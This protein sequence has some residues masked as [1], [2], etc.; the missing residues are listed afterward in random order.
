MT[1][2]NSQPPKT[3]LGRVMTQAINTMMHFGGNA[4]KPG[5]KVPELHIEGQTQP[6]S[7][8]GDRHTGGRSSSRD[9]TIRNET[10]SANHFLLRKDSEHPRHFVIQDDKSSNGIYVNNRKV[11]SFSLRNGDTIHLAPPELAQAVKITYRFTPPIWV[12]LIRYGLMGSGGF[13]GF[14]CLIFAWQWTKYPLNPLPSGVTG[15]VVIFSRD[16]ATA[17][18]PVTTDSHR[19]LKRLREFSPYLSKGLITSE[20]ARFYWHVGV[21]PIGIARAVKVAVT[22]GNVTQGASTITQQVARSLF[23]EV[24]SE[25]TASRKLREMIVALKME[26][27][28]SKNEILLLYLNKVYLG[29]GQ[30]G[31]EDAAQFYFD[32]SARDLDVLESATLIAMLPAPNAFNPIV[33]PEKSREQR[34]LVIDRMHKL[35]VIT[36]QEQRQAKLTPIEDRLSEEAR[37]SLSN[38]AAPY[39]YGYV[40]QELTE[41]LGDN[42]LKMG[43]LYI[44]TGLDIPMQ[45]TAAAALEAA[46]DQDG[47]QVG[48]SQGAIATI[49][50]QT[51]EILAMVGGKDYRESQFNRATQAQRQPGSTFKVFGYGAAIAAGIS[52]YTAFS[53]AP[54]TWQGQQFRGC[55]R[56]STGQADMYRGVAQ[57]ENAIALRVAQDVGLKNVIS[58]AEQLGITS[59]LNASPGLIL[60]ESEVSVLEMS[61]AYATFANGG[62]WNKPHAIRRIYDS[63]DCTGNT[64][65]SCYLLY[66]FSKRT[67]FRREQVISSGTAQTMTNLLQG[68]IQSGTG[69][70]ARLGLDEAGKTGTTNSA[71]DLWFVGYVPSKDLTTA[72]WLGNDDN[73]PTRGS[74]Y[75]AAKLWGTYMR[76]AF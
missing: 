58:F 54:L 24:G 2:P 71:V 1:Q 28:F 39:F 46:I 44:E 12:Q 33:D 25:K 45:Q 69:Q 49:D 48:F 26:T 35:G 32:K 67:D 43:N 29:V 19:E 4:L 18:N 75:Y 6:F 51:G 21:D 27:F 34:N 64:I 9:I 13:I 37:R 53:C 55:E 14:L 23:P 70:V 65:D 63:S 16:G 66:D 8:V 36:D 47:A 17:I 5:A 10:V 31:F 73:T 76:E 72:I 22:N 40:Q 57:S 60:G 61:G 59:K 38:N 68:V 11:K 62:T 20:D 41:L 74:S 7:L 15:P 50:S 3:Q 42:A 56:T 30:S 52:P